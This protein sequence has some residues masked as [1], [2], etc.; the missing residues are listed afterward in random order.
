MYDRESDEYE[1]A[2]LEAL[3]EGRL[4]DVEDGPAAQRLEPL[5]AAVAQ[6]R[7]VAARAAVIEAWE[8]D[9]QGVH[10][11][12]RLCDAPLPTDDDWC[13]VCGRHRGNRFW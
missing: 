10:E 7:S 3:I 5:I 4:L 13:V 9:P 1:G 12:C 6:N 2:F 11:F 8:S